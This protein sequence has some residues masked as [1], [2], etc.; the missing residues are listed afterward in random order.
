VHVAHRERASAASAYNSKAELL[1]RTHLDRSA[2]NVALGRSNSRSRFVAR[3][4]L[5]RNGHG[6]RNHRPASCGRRVRGE[7]VSFARARQTFRLLVCVE[8]RENVWRLH[9]KK[10]NSRKSNS[11]SRHTRTRAQGAYPLP[12]APPLTRVKDHHGR[13]KHRRQRPHAPRCAGIRDVPAPHQVP[14]QAKRNPRSGA[15]ASVRFRRNRGGAEETHR[16]WGRTSRQSSFSCDTHGVI[17]DT[18]PLA[19]EHPSRDAPRAARA[20]RATRHSQPGN[21]F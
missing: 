2:Y 17:L 5:I 13:R 12:L 14:T 11:N 19:P 18:S 8:H 15:S 20:T 4:P 6:R 3:T 1:P 16:R 9:E 7:R 21:S 10:Q